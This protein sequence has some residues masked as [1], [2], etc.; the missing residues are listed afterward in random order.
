[1]H[2]RER[3]AKVSV[4]LVPQQVLTNSIW[5][6]FGTSGW[7]ACGPPHDSRAPGLAVRTFAFR[8]VQKLKKFEIVLPLLLPLPLISAAPAASALRNPSKFLNCSKSQPPQP[9]QPFEILRNYS[10]SFKSQPPQPPQPFEILRNYLKSC[11]SQPPQPP[12]PF[13]IF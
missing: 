12:Q 4:S 13:E 2:R 8:D 10:K 11:Q 3:I 7:L 9:P 6:P 1:M 5:D